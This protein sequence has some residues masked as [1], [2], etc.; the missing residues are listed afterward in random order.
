VIRAFHDWWESLPPELKE[1][2]YQNDKDV[3]RLNHVNY[4]WIT[5]LMNN[6]SEEMN[7]TVEELLEWVKTGQINAKNQ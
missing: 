2:D 5:N 7:P 6:N 1:K 4:I 3:P